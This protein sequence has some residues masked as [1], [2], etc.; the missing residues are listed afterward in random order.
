MAATRC[1]S[2]M[3]GPDTMAP[4]AA[5]DAGLDTEPAVVAP[6]PRTRIPGVVYM[7]SELLDFYVRQGVLGQAGVADAFRAAARRFP[8]RIALSQGGR[9]VTYRQLDDMTDRAAAALLDLGLRPLDP[10]LFQLVN[11]QAL[12]VSFLGCLKAGLIP[13][14]TL[15]AH[16]AS[17]I[18]QIG[19]QVRARAHIISA[20]AGSFDLIPFAM[21][22]RGALPDLAY[23]IVAD[24]DGVVP[25]GM[26][27]LD[28][29]IAR[30]DLAHARAV[31][32]GVALDPFQVVVY[33][34]SGGTTGVPKV[35]P[36]FA[37]EYLHS[38]RSIL[39][40]FGFDETLVTFTGNPMMH[41]APTLCFWLPALV[42]GGEVAIAERPD[43]ASIARVV[44]DRKPT[45]AIIAPV[46]LRMMLDDGMVT[47]HDFA[48]IYGLATP[49]GATALG[50]RVNAPALHLYGMTEG[51]LTHCRAE[52]PTHAR[53]ITV[54]RPISPY[55]EVRIVVPGTT[56][57][58]RPGETGELIVRGPCTIHGYFDSPERNA[59]AFTPDGYY[60]SGDLMR[61]QV[62]EGERY[63]KFEGRLKDVVDRG[64]EKIN[65]SEIELAVA[66]LSGI[67]NV[68]CVGMPD[69]IYGER[70]CAF[71][72]V[73]TG[74]PPPTV[75]SI[76]AHLD[77]IGLAR[78]KFPER[79]EIVAEFPMTMSG[80][81]SKPLLKAQIAAI[82]ERESQRAD[83]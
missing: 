67:A 24:E 76:A 82:L 55:D 47:Q 66:R 64:G 71:V 40:Y 60:R 77:I 70:L 25:D 44:L 48:N 83:A 63:L 35:I 81:P 45:W 14:C 79:V 33:Q 42:A 8:D 3:S 2:S 36:R 28:A 49:N 30:T 26:H 61:W 52:D 1:G 53:E 38:A 34:L 7:P 23:T 11:S 5:P 32:S 58:V 13:V 29:L 65:C 72:I 54:G 9:L 50:A 69:P 59:E 21:A 39:K 20:R 4:P 56:L 10:V 57:D 15:A 74:H 19:G 22:M 80:K 78:F 17:E 37:N 18:G 46:Y 27:R 62:I 68:A 6:G 75:A 31:L 51:L 12:V 73:D 41:N 43:A 16:R